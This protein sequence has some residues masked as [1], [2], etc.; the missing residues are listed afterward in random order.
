MSRSSI[1]DAHTEGPSSTSAGQPTR[2]AGA[3]R[4]FVGLWPDFEGTAARTLAEEEW[5]RFEPEPA[6][7]TSGDAARPRPPE[8]EQDSGAA[9][10]ELRRLTGLTWDQLARLFRV[11]RRSL[12]FWASGKPLNSANEEQL[13]RT[14]ATVRAIDRGS[15]AENRLELGPPRACGLRPVARASDAERDGSRRMLAGR[16][17]SVDVVTDEIAIGTF[18]EAGRDR[19]ELRADRPRLERLGE[20]RHVLKG[21]GS[22]RPEPLRR[23]AVAEQR[24]PLQVLVGELA[25]A[26]STRSIDERC[27]RP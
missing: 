17:A 9:V 2:A 19:D 25:D 14:L 20:L 3:A 13:Y 4:H 15:A 16:S 24:S 11:A 12:L 5:S 7:T 1:I 26:K 8:A 22:A 23:G 21:P 10:L 6:Q 18:L 27:V